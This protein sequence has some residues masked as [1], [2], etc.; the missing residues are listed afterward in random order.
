MILQMSMQSLLRIFLNGSTLNAVSEPCVQN[1]PVFRLSRLQLIWQL[2]LRFWK[3]WS[4]VYLQW[5]KSM[6]KWKHRDNS[7]KK[8]SLLLILD[9]QYPLTKWLLGRIL[10]VHPG[11]DGL[12]RVASV[13]TSL[14]TF[15]SP[16]AKLCPL[17]LGDKKDL[18]EWTS[19]A[20]NL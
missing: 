14:S 15:K 11:A 10:D 3:R 4:N 16:V 9:G 12:V 8:K 18:N 7:I 19:C 2:A 20:K 5:F 6:S 17:P 13:K 1:L